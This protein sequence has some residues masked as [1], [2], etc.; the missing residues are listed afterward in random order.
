M[1]DQGIWWKLW[2][3][4]LDDPNLDNLPISDFGRYCKLG[5]LVK[6]HGTAGSLA[7]S[8]PSR[9]LC[10]MFQVPDYETLLV[11]FRALPHVTIST[12]SLETIAVVSFENWAK[13][14]GDLS[15]HRVKRFREVKRYRR[16]EKRGEVEEKRITPSVSP[17]L[18]GHQSHDQ[19]KAVLA[20]LNQTTHRGYRETPATLR[21]IECRLEAGASVQD[22]KTIIARKWREWG[23]DPKMTSYVRPATLFN[24]TK[25]EQYRGELNL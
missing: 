23:T 13:Y 20:F 11:T 15:T 2:A 12:V 14:Q 24:A 3:S 21:M 7:V 10:A 25:F 17:S 18:N 8:P 16:E 5:A 1:A 6:R 9:T 22:C 4:A 19:A